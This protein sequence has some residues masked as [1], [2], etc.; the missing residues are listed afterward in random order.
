M[1]DNLCI[2]TFVLICFFVSFCNNTLK[3]MIS[4]SVIAIVFVWFSL[5]QIFALHL[6]LCMA[7][8]MCHGSDRFLFILLSQHFGRFIFLT[9]DLEKSFWVNNVLHTRISWLQKYHAIL[10]VFLR[11]LMSLIVRYVWWKVRNRFSMPFGIRKYQKIT[12]KARI[13]LLFYVILLGKNGTIYSSSS[14]LLYESGH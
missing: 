10:K 4:F 12:P 1:F 14:M 6:T 8:L 9:G 2:I 11:S 13:M 7:I 5:L 3:K